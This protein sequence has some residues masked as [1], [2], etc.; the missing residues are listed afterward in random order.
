MIRK[1]IPLL[2]LAAAC[3]DRNTV[4]RDAEDI[5]AKAPLAVHKDINRRIRYVKHSQRRT[6]DG[7]LAIRVVMASKSRKDRAMIGRTSWLDGNGDV[8]EQSDERSFLVPSGGTYVYEDTSWNPKAQDFNV[9][10]REANMK[11]KK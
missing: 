10:V 1:M 11:R 5:E 9:A 2:L 7:R 6:D 8:I 4:A 3:T